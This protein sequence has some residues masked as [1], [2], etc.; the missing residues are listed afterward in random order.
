MKF[1]IILLTVICSAAVI[2]DGANA[3]SPTGTSRN[4][5]PTHTT[6]RP[7]FTPMTEK[8]LVARRED[9]L[10][11]SFNRYNQHKIAPYTPLTPL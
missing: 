11:R 6:S 10:S 8:Q 2:E 5:K 7:V 1:S 9:I 3:S 4:R